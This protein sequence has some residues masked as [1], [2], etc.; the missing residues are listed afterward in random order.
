MPSVKNFLNAL[1]YTYHVDKRELLLEAARM[2]T[3]LA[4]RELA[5]DPARN[6]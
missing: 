6:K 3:A 1:V 5:V 2:C 4:E